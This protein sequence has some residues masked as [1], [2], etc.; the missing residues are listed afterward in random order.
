MEADRV[1]QRTLFRAVLICLT[2]GSSH[3]R[4]A[5]QGAWRGTVWPLRGSSVLMHV[6]GPTQNWR[7]KD[8]WEPLGSGDEAWAGPPV[9]CMTHHMKQ[10][11]EAAGDMHF[12]CIF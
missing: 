6:A 11:A 2:G 5:T 3:R 4:Q 10:E 12:K 8:R 7:R 9:L 1:G